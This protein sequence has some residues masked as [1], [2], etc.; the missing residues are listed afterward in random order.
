MLE[1]KTQRLFNHFNG[2]IA[3]YS[4]EKAIKNDKLTPYEYHTIN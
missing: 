4:L 3:E 1:D 2:V